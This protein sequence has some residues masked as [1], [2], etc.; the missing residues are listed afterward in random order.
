MNAMTLPS[1]LPVAP[2]A[3]VEDCR[4]PV[5]VWELLR[6]TYQDQH[7]GRL[8][9]GRHI[10]S[11][12]RWMQYM[13]EL[14]SDGRPHIHVDAGAVHRVVCGILDPE[15]ARLVVEVAQ[16]GIEPEPCTQ[17]P[18][19]VPMPNRE[20]G[21]GGGPYTIRGAWIEVPMIRL[22]Q[23]EMRKL[24]ETGDHGEIE[25]SAVPGGA[26]RW[27]YR[28]DLRKRRVCRRAKVIH[29]ANGTPRAKNVGF[30][31]G[32]QQWSPYCV[33]DYTPSPEYVAMVNAIHARWVE[34]L[35]ALEAALLEVPFR[36]RRLVPRSAKATSTL[37]D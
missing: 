27:R 32:D 25:R 12:M 36:T 26:L 20:R 24:T 1:T 21:Q 35:R 17:I 11:R 34:A 4:I 37:I 18:R 9:I 3:D 31:E 22:T 28:I 2:P 6:W 15:T 14:D 7:A 33:V 8:G 19:P 23:A 16:I 13:A 5:D 29:N 10:V 30:A